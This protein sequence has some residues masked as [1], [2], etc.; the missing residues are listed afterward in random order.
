MSQEGVPVG[1]SARRPRGRIG[2]YALSFLLLLAAGATL[3]VEIPPSIPLIW[4][5]IGCSAVAILAAV[6]GVVGRR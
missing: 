5:S 3:A 6:V 2:A 4:T 1:R